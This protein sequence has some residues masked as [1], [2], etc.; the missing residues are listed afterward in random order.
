M[1]TSTRSSGCC[2]GRNE[3]RNS[4][5]RDFSRGPRPVSLPGFRRLCW[6]SPFP[7]SFSETSIS[8]SLFPLP[9]SFILPVS[10]APSPLL[11]PSSAV[12]LRTLPFPPSAKLPI[13]RGVGQGYT[14]RPHRAA[15]PN[16]PENLWLNATGKKGRGAGKAIPI[17]DASSH[18]VKVYWKMLCYFAGIEISRL[19]GVDTAEEFL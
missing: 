6:S 1:N 14:K 13:F 7:V 12:R 16:S 11:C 3:R 17:D 2:T 18:Q 15:L 8:H 9:R 5:G 10:F 19:L 4:E